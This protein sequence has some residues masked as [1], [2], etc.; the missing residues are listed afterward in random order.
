MSLRVTAI[1][2]PWRLKA[3]A[4]P[5]KARISRS[6]VHRCR[7]CA[8]ATGRARLVYASPTRLAAIVPAGLEGGRAPVRVAGASDDDLAVGRHRRRRSPPASIR[9]TTRSSIATAISTSPTAA[10]AASR[11]RSRFSACGPTARASRSRRASST[12]RRMAIDPRGRLYVS[13]R[14]EG[15]VYRVAPDGSAEPFAH[16]LGVACGLAF[17]ADGTLFVGD[18]SG[19]IFRVD[20]G[21]RADDC[22]RRC[23]RA[24]P[25]SIWRSGR[26][27][28]LRHRADAVVVRPCSIASPRTARSTTVARAVRPAA[29]AGVRSRAARCLSSKRWPG[30]AACIELRPRQR[31]GAGA[32]RAR[33]WSASPS[34]PPAASSSRR[35]TPRIAWSARPD[36]RRLAVTV[37]PQRLAPRSRI[38]S[39]MSQL[40][41]RKPIAALVE[42][43]EGDERPEAHPSAPAI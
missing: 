8:S 12:R 1:H 7:R 9:S 13:S 5:S 29:G 42:D 25:R 26:R 16:D 27:C 6:T 38:R 15:A 34:T 21:G 30:R 24:S 40:F 3:A 37:A 4:S 10:R 2:P 28:A 23:R 39:S 36:A 18:R 41:Q 43:T 32:C 14:F 35:T 17:C 22:S 20:G 31:A 33:A 19:T 11:C